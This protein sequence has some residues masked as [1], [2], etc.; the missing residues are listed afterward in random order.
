MGWSRATGQWRE[1]QACRVLRVPWLRAAAPRLGRRLFQRERHVLVGLRRGERQ[2]P[3]PLLLPADRPSQPGVRAAALSR[4][5]GGGDRRGEQR[6]GETHSA[7]NDIDDP[8]PAAPIEGVGTAITDN[9]LEDVLRRLG[10]QRR[11][12][13]HVAC[14]RRQA[15]DP[16]EEEVM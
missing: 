11:E 12:Q 9:P 5:G 7:G 3:G 1:G 4:G 14:R 15:T 6:V 8:R 10:Q 16:V 13:Q 2:V